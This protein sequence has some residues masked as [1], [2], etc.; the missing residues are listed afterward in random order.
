MKNTFKHLI[1]A[2]LF[3]AVLPA[4][5]AIQHY[6]FSGQVSSGFYAGESFSG[7]FSFDD[8]T[9][10][11][12]GSE[13]INLSSLS[14]SFLG[15]TFTEASFLESLPDVAFDQGA[16]LGLAWS[17]NSITPEIGFSFING[18]NNASEAYFSYDT[19]LGF[20]GEGSVV[21]APVPEA[22]TYA[23]LIAG[24]GLVGFAARR[25]TA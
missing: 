25:K 20:S 15:T 2:A 11:S 6:S 16:F 18:Y 17:V 10:S 21:Y 22:D 14:M 13:Y 4:Q 24:L 5:A 9:L 8:A 12:V 7:S 3:S 23:M 19:S 1:V